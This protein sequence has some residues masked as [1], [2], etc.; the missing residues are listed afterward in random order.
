MSAALEAMQG[1]PPEQNSVYLTQSE[2]DPPEPEGSFFNQQI[3]LPAEWL[4]PINLLSADIRYLLADE[5]FKKNRIDLALEY[6]DYL[7]SRITPGQYQFGDPEYVHSQIAPRLFLDS[8]ALMLNQQVYHTLSAKKGRHS[9][10]TF[11]DLLRLLETK[12]TMQVGISDYVKEF[13]DTSGDILFNNLLGM[14]NHARR[15]VYTDEVTTEKTKNSNMQNLIGM[16]AENKVVDA[17]QKND[18]PGTCHASISQD[19]IGV[20]VIVP[21]EKHGSAVVLQVKSHRLETTD[22]AIKPEFGTPRV[23]V[24]MNPRYNNPFRLDDLATNLLN[25][26]IYNAPRVRLSLAA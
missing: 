21:T 26:F 22:F 6:T 20:D 5:K 7:R 2:N 16:L 10:D 13:P 25:K 18:W 1:Q 15:V 8:I 11:G 3:A 12:R 4:P 9:P 24:P 14:M 19:A 17:L 23:I